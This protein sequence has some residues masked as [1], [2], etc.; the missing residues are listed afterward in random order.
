MD[1]SIFDRSRSIHTARLNCTQV[2]A[3]VEPLGVQFINR[4]VAT[5]SGK[6]MGT[7][8]GSHLAGRYVG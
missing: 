5:L 2:F 4:S 7:S 3:G 6:D 8:G 1:S